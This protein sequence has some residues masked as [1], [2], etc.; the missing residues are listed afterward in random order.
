MIAVQCYSVLTQSTLRYVRYC[1]YPALQRASHMAAGGLDASHNGN[2][3]LYYSIVL[4]W[5][6]A[7]GM[8]GSHNGTRLRRSPSCE[9]YGAIGDEK[10]ASHSASCRHST[11]QLKRLHSRSCG[12]GAVL[13]CRQALARLAASHSCGARVGAYSH[14]ARSGAVL[15][16][17]S[18]AM[19]TFSACARSACLRRTADHRTD[20]AVCD[21]ICCAKAVPCRAVPCRAV[22]CLLSAL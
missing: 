12:A 11:A 13:A 6:R 7:D 17:A 15:L 4:S 9:P 21:S 22:P 20:S 18:D 14:C 2:S 16:T 10:C 19:R 1:G 8:Q 5:L 3:N